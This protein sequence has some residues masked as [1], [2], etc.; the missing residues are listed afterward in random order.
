M[1]EQPSSSCHGACGHVN[2][3]KPL[4]SFPSAGCVLDTT[5][6]APELLVGAGD[7]CLGCQACFFWN[8]FLTLTV[9]GPL[10]DFPLGELCR[11]LKGGGTASSYLKLSVM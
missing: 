10:A 4:H 2:P 6:S 1:T 3:P 11:L 9:A 8:P 5:V 7:F